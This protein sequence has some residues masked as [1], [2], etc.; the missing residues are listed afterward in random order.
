[1]IIVT[2]V[3][4]CRRKT[5]NRKTDH[6]KLDVK[7]IPRRNLN[8]N[9][10]QHPKLK[11]PESRITRHGYLPSEYLQHRPNDVGNQSR[12]ISHGYSPVSFH[13]YPRTSVSEDWKDYGNRY[14]AHYQP[15][16][17][18]DDMMLYYTQYP[19]DGYSRISKGY[20]QPEPY[21]MQH[22]YHSPYIKEYDKSI[23]SV[24]EEKSN[25]RRGN[26]ESSW[27]TLY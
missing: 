2:V 8:S 3:L 25:H 14:A 23:K 24:V 26:Y 21:R 11:Y 19:G 5:D 7:K 12:M 20:R 4:C 27:D 9:R 6:D 1:V 15:Y 18:D 16:R 17:G 10:R 13:H 22:A